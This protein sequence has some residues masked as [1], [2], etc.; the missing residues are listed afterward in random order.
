M[1]SLTASSCS[2]HYLLFETTNTNK[3]KDC[4]HGHILARFIVRQSCLSDVFPQLFLVLKSMMSTNKVIH[5]SCLVT[6]AIR[7][8]Y[9]YKNAELLTD[10]SDSNVN[11]WGTSINPLTCTLAG[12]FRLRKYDME[13]T[14][15]LGL[16][17]MMSQLRENWSN[18]K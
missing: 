18:F 4:Y 10:S 7:I 6:G 15:A 9:W 1:S 16:D 17:E 5:G 12:F 2:S 11:K 14:F 8:Y 3:A 13:L